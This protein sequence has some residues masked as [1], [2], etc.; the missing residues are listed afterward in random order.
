MVSVTKRCFDLYSLIP[1]VG[2]CTVTGVSLIS[3]HVNFKCSASRV[4][5]LFVT[6]ITL[7]SSFIAW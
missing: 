7:N 4:C 5:Q 6:K 3:V 2:F 1:M